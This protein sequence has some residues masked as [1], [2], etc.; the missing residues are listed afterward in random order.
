MKTKDLQ[1]ELSLSLFPL[2]KKD[3]ETGFNGKG[4]FENNMCCGDI[5]HTIKCIF[6]DCLEN[7]IKTICIYLNTPNVKSEDEEIK[8]KRFVNT[9]LLFIHKYRLVYNVNIKILKTN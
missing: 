3:L 7:K 2:T 1:N 9:V 8:L 6:M 4:L 5:K